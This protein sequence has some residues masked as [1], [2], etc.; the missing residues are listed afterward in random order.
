MF[1]FC[2]N[3]PILTYRDD[4][5]PSHIR[6]HLSTCRIVEQWDGNKIKN[7]FSSPPPFHNDVSYDMLSRFPEAELVYKSD[8]SVCK[9]QLDPCF[10]EKF[11]VYVTHPVFG[12]LRTCGEVSAGQ[13]LPTFQGHLNLQALYSIILDIPVATWQQSTLFFF[14][15]F[16]SFSL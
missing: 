12:L 2:F 9:T 13:L 15:L 7:L 14:S 3:A 10:A 4:L 1:R 8:G 5:D 11:T 6:M 16:F